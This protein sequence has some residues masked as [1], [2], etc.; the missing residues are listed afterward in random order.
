MEFELFSLGSRCSQRNSRTWKS[1]TERRW[2]LDLSTIL[3]GYDRTG[4]SSNKANALSFTVTRRSMKAHSR[5]EENE[6]TEEN[7]EEE[8]EEEEVE[9]EEIVGSMEVEKFR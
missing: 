2:I 4:F 5:N 7:E 9:E 8:E 3:H 1:L 6:E